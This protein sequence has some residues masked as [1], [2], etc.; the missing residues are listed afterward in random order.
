MIIDTENHNNVATVELTVQQ[1]REY[2]D[3]PDDTA[4]QELITSALDIAQ[5]DVF[6]DKYKSYYVVIRVA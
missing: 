2:L 4:T 1:V 6:S 5:G 3:A